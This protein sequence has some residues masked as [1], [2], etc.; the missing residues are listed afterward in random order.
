MKRVVLTLLSLALVLAGAAL[1]APVSP[2]RAA[3]TDISTGTV[4]WGIKASWR[5]YIGAHN[6][7]TGGGATVS[8][9]TGNVADGFDFPV[10]SGSYDDA[11]RTTTLQLAGWVRFQAYRDDAGRYALDSTFTDLE[12]RMGPDAQEIRG[13]YVGYSRDD[14]GGAMEE[15]VDVVLATLDPAGAA[16]TSFEADR[17]TWDAIP[18]QGGD[19]QALYAPGTTFDPVSVDYEGPGGMPDLAERFAE[20]GAPVLG[21]GAR[22]LSGSA[23]S[24]GN[25]A[26]R[27]LEVSA[28]GDLV[29]AVQFDAA[30]GAQNLI[31]TALDAQELTPVGTPYTHPMVATGSAGRFLRTAIDPATDTIFFVTAKDGTAQ[32]EVTLRTVRFDRVNGTFDAGVVGAIA[33]STSPGVGN[34][35]WNRASGELGVLVS[36]ASTATEQNPYVLVRVRPT[37]DGWSVSRAPVQWPASGDF[38]GGW[39]LSRTTTAS[40]SNDAVAS[41]AALGDGSYVVATNATSVRVDGVDHYA[42]AFRLLPTGDSAVEVSGIADTAAKPFDETGAVHYG[43]AAATAG[44]GGSVYLHGLNQRLDDYQR[45]E[46]E[47]GAAIARPATVGEPIPLYLEY[48]FRTSRIAEM[49][50]Y[51]ADRGFLW[52]SDDSDTAGRTLKLVDDSGTLAGY[53]IAEFSRGGGGAMVIR[54]GVDGSVYVPIQS[55]ANPREF[56]YRRMVFEGIAPEVTT[57]PED[58]AVELARGEAK[59]PVSLTAAIDPSLGGEVQWQARRPGESRFRDVPGATTVTL[60]VDATPATGGTTYRLKVA[61]DAGVVVSDEASLEVNYAPRFGLDARG[62]TVTEGSDATFVVNAQASPQL[63]A[64]TWQRRVGGYWQ[65]IEE[66]DDNVVVETADGVSSLT[67]VGT[68]VDQSG[69]LF[70][71]KAVNPVGT[72]YSA[73]ARLTVNAKRGVPAAGLALDGVTLEWS[74]SEELQSAPPFGGSNYLSAGVSAGDEASYRAVEGDVAILHRAADGAETPARWATRAAP[75]AGDVDQLVRLS[76]GHAQLAADGSGRVRWEGS[77]SVNFYGGLVPFWLTDPELVVAA[78]G[79]GTLTADIDG[80]GSSMANPEQ[81]TPLDAV[82]DV[83]IATFSDVEIDPAG[84]VTVTPAYAGVEVDLP[85]E[86]TQQN[87]TAEGWGAWPQAFV[88]VHLATGLSSYWYSSGGAADGKK[89]PA[90]FSVDFTDAEVVASGPGPTGPP[91][92]VAKVV[93]TLALAVGRARVGKKAAARVTVTLPPGSAAYSGQVVILAGDRI[94]GVRRASVASGGT[95]SIKLGKGVLRRLGAGR[96]FLTAAVRATATTLAATSDVVAV[97]VKKKR[98]R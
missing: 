63:T 59:R 58:V 64:V 78:D 43:W 84:E 45:V 5:S 25:N 54:T 72:T 60:Q 89:P 33:T 38:P 83:P 93:P 15:Y 69:S 6:T 75:V 22:W 19:G 51:D 13:T 81:R 91:A 90:P 30:H 11:T 47:G 42:P 40:S 46:V 14:P 53:R 29:Y 52:A 17:T 3:S 86:V 49:L 95:V 74:G 48:G 9:V 39:G 56:G 34:L 68:N 35:T 85:A 21:E 12:L 71:A 23:V 94:L 18:S 41:L 27:S 88:D 97:K 10:T 20:P 36:S 87:R 77:F 61:N 26:S 2:A 79:T 92:E 57:Q 80:Y 82:A 50:A 28:Q 66:D 16:G 76:G 8:G 62:R 32:N 98:R 1:V 96:H 44:P 65:P 70:R 4:S 37:D 67:V 24:G 31:F 73:A 55:A 7:T